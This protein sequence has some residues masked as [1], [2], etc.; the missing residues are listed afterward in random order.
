MKLVNSTGE[1]VYF[2]VVSKHGV[3]RYVV[4]A[5]DGQVISGRDRQ[6]QKSRSFAQQYQAEAWLERN[7]YRKTLY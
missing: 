2:N 7:G 5:V 3:T 4:K 6:K 1:A